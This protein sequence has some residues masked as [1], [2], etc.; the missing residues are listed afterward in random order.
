M[1][2][3]WPEIAASLPIDR[4]TFLRGAAAGLPLAY[5]LLAGGEGYAAEGQRGLIVRQKDPDNLEFPFA[6]LNLSVK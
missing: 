1:S 3:L 2:V 6:T 5:A 4:R